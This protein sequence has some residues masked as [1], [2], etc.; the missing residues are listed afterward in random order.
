MN[1]RFQVEALVGSWRRQGARRK[2]SVKAF[3]TAIV[4]GLLPWLAG[5]A[6]AGPAEDALLA[7]WMGVATNLTTWEATVVQT[8]HL[9]A[10]TQ[11][12]VSTGHVW[13]AAPVSFR[14]QLGQPAQSIALRSSNEL[15]VLSPRLRRAERHALGEGAVG[16]VND[17]MALLD[18]GFPRDVEG[19]R[20][21]FEVLGVSS[22]AGLA[23]LQ[24][25][26]RDAAARRMMPSMGIELDPESMQVRA[27]ELTFADGSRLRNAFSEIVTNGVIPESTFRTNLDSGWKT[28]EGRKTP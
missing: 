25:R 21:R 2:M 12:L 23:S 8:R 11:P 10:L 3:R 5:L 1:C 7:R 24:L 17:L 18:A 26:P 4:A 27:T 19:F 16:P 15:V 6:W 9:K 20:R 14:W 28:T 13:F 22:N